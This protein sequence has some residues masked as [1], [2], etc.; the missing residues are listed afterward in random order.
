M[1]RVMKDS[2]FGNFNLK[3]WT[4]KS[5]RSLLWQCYQKARNKFQIYLAVRTARARS[6]ITAWSG[7]FSPLNRFIFFDLRL[8]A[9][10]LFFLFLILVFSFNFGLKLATRGQVVYNFLII[11]MQGK[12]GPTY[13]A[14]LNDRL[15]ISHCWL[16]KSVRIWSRRFYVSIGIDDSWRILFA[17][18]PLTGSCIYYSICLVPNISRLPYLTGCYRLSLFFIMDPRTNASRSSLLHPPPTL[19]FL[20]CYFLVKY[21]SRF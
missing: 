8:P 13:I 4:T 19:K 20:R 9:V 15:S 7:W 1:K 17:A 6:D 18:L 5:S 10:N 11:I 12:T 2:N 21:D 16:W 3:E 14:C